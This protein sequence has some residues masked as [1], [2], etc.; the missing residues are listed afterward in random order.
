MVCGVLE[1]DIPLLYP[2]GGYGA[3][4]VIL[5]AESVERATRALQRI[6]DVKSGDGF[7]GKYDAT[8]ATNQEPDN[9]RTHRL[10]CSV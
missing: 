7:A 6:D 5:S 4:G 1:S 3:D 9:E 10:A 8:S 2:I